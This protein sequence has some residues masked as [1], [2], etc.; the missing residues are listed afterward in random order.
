MR[1]LNLSRVL[2]IVASAA[3]RAS[4]TVARMFS[5]RMLFLQAPATRRRASDQGWLRIPVHV[6]QDS[7]G[8]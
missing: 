7:G 1:V 3:G 4:G 6:N 2:S 5:D 8:M